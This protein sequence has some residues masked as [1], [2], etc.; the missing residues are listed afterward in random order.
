V[1]WQRGSRGIAA[2]A[3]VS[4]LVA[5]CGRQDGLDPLA[6]QQ[7]TIDQLQMMAAW[8][9]NPQGVGFLGAG[10]VQADADLAQVRG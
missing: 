8:E 6:E 4:L 5:G 2:L 1:G 7:Y 9:Q 3:A 10:I